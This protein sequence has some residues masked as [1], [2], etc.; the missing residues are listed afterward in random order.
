MAFR[1]GGNN[2]RN[3]PRQPNN[4]PRLPHQGGYNRMSDEGLEKSAEQFRP[5]RSPH[6]P[7][8]RGPQDTQ[9]GNY[10]GNRGAYHGGD[11]KP[12]GRQWYDSPDHP[13]QHEYRPDS[14]PGGPRPG[15]Y[16]PPRQEGPRQQRSEYRP[17][18][19]G[20]PIENRSG[21]T[22]IRWDQ[23]RRPTQHGEQRNPGNFRPLPQQGFRKRV[24]DTAPSYSTNKTNKM[25]D[26]PRDAA[27]PIQQRDH[28]QR[29]PREFD[30]RPAPSPIRAQQTL[31]EENEDPREATKEYILAGRNPIREALKAGRDLEKL[32]VAKGDL[33][34]SARE[35]VAIAHERHIPI[36]EVDRAALDV[37]ANAHQGLIAYAS[38]Y[39]YAQ[40][41]DI[42]ARAEE[43]GQEPFVIILDGITDPHNLGA[44]IRTAECAGAHGVIVP[45]RRAVGLTSAAVKA[46]AGAV[47][48]LPVV[49]VTNITKLIEM[50]KQRGLWIIAGM[51]QGEPYEKADLSGP[52]ALVIG[53][54]GDGISRLVLDN[55]DKK[56][57]V[58]LLGK[59]GSL[60]ASVAAGVLMYEVVRRRRA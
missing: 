9:G 35:I 58:P 14:R 27:P 11:H 18:R 8:F 19:P 21:Y 30:R 20:R 36:Q 41:E 34:G 25:D 2:K 24:G 5:D 12:Y 15:G 48:H 59:T 42:F 38:A 10:G 54:E 43:R 53:G 52:I 1:N 47:E 44:I 60:N 13:D 33:S 32:M 51:E 16:G 29:P 45:E 46:S 31:A 6:H 26:M 22:P 57:T 23:Q 39:K 49:R 37:V 55:C 4:R 28:I 50:L 3:G 56:I 40:L 17:T 7:D